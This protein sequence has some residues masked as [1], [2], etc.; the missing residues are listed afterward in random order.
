MSIANTPL[1]TAY[2]AA[3]QKLLKQSHGLEHKP[4]IDVLLS[5]S[6]LEDGSREIAEIRA[7]QNP[8]NQQ[9]HYA[10]IE[11][12]FRSIF[13]SLI[14]SDCCGTRLKAVSD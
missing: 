4:S 11:T 1:V 5:A 3:I 7:S 8:G 14:V 10:A 2:T 12:A 9:A 13:S 6:Q